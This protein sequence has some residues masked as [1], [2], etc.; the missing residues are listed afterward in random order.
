MCWC[1]WQVTKD[2]D[3]QLRNKSQSMF[4]FPIWAHVQLFHEFNC[5]CGVNNIGR[6]SRMRSFYQHNRYAVVANCFCENIQRKMALK[7]LSCGSKIWTLNPAKRNERLQKKHLKWLNNWNYHHIFSFFS[8]K[9]I[10]RQ[11][12]LALWQFNVCLQYGAFLPSIVDGFVQMLYSFTFFSIFLF[13]WFSCS[14]GC[15]LPYERCGVQTTKCMEWDQ[16]ASRNI[17]VIKTMAWCRLY[18][19]RR[20][21][22]E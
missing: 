13:S 3:T 11:L 4:V 21:K 2:Y 9:K 20:R 19:R 7:G 14:V 8:G 16:M 1:A 17:E 5:D 22:K 15:L 6:S 10:F 12:Q 18:Q